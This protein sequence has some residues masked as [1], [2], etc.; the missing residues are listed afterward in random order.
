MERSV[1][2]GTRDVLRGGCSVRARRGRSPAYGA[3]QGARL[4]V[5]ADNRS[6]PDRLLWHGIVGA[7]LE[8]LG[9]YDEGA[10][11]SSASSI[12]S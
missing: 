12:A 5:S 10:R 2:R 7:L 1:G 8:T 11:G 3:N 9:A 6:R 4:R